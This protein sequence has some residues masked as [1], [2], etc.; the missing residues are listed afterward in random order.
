[1][2]IWKDLNGLL[3]NG[4]G[5]CNTIYFCSSLDVNVKHMM[6]FTRLHCLRCPFIDCHGMSSQAILLFQFSVQQVNGLG[7]LGRATIQSLLKQISSSLQLLA[8]VTVN[9]LGEVRVPDV[10]NIG[11]PEESDATLICFETLL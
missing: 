1:M 9:E 4:S 8:S 3:I 7:K 2:L 10:I 6:S 11:P 5:V